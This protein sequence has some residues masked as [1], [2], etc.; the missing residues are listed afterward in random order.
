MTL[1][2]L[3]DAEDKFQMGAKFSI[4]IYFSKKMP[5]LRQVP[6]GLTHSCGLVVVVVVVVVVITHY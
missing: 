3:G 4:P 2:A 5:K 6:S 1:K